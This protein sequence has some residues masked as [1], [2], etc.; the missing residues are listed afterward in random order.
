MSLFSTT[1]IMCKASSNYDLMS[2]F[3][4]NFT[5]KPIKESDII[6]LLFKNSLSLFLDAFPKSFVSEVIREE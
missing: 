1:R 3:V 2:S 6:S 4:G 5:F